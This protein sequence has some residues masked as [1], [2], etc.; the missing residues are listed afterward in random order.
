MI[1]KIKT[2]TSLA[3]AELV[4]HHMCMLRLILKS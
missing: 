1:K 3:V 4:L 2:E